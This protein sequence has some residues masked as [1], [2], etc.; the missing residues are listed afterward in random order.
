MH[1]DT[2]V[3]SY[4]HWDHSYNL[5]LFPAAPIYI[6]KKELQYAVAPLPSDNR[7]YPMNPK[8]GL[9]GWYGRF[10]KNESC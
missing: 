7:T 1:G 10:F 5:E 3:V 8:N 9:P 4:A 6:Q 2:G